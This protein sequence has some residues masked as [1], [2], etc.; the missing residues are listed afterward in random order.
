M[1]LTRTITGQFGMWPWFRPLSREIYFETVVAGGAASVVVA[2]T[3]SLACLYGCAWFLFRIGRRLLG[4]QAAVM[5]VALFLTYNATKFLTAWA[6]GFQDLLAAFL[7]LLAV[8]AW[9][10]G[11][12]G[13]ALVSAALAP[14]AK[15]SGF[16]VYPL[17][18][19]AAYMW[20]GPQAKRDW[21]VRLG[22]TGIVVAS[23]HFLVRWSWQGVGTPPEAVSAERLP[24]VLGQA[25]LGF[26][27]P[28]PPADDAALWLGVGAG[29]ATAALIYVCTSDGKTNH[30]P[31]RATTEGI[32]FVSIA[33]GLAL[34]PV[35]V[36]HLLR[37]TFAHAYQLFPAAPWIALL[38]AGLASALPARVWQT[39]TV[40]LVAW[41]V[42]ALGFRVPDL[43]DPASWSF[44]RWDW[45]EAV[46]F[47]AVSQ[48]L[49]DDIRHELASRPESLI[50]LYEEMP[51][52][53]F[54]QTEDG[55]ATREALQDRTVRAYWASEPPRNVESHRLAILKFDTERFHLERER[56][57]TATAIHRAMNA[58]LAG[59]GR[60]A[61]VFARYDGSPDSARFDRA[62]LL[63]ASALLEDGP[64]AYVQALAVGG[65]ADTTSAT[66]D[67]IAGPLSSIDPNLG[68]ALAEALRHPL[69]AISHAAL[70]DTLLRRGVAARAGMELRI[71]T[72]LDP[73]RLGDRYQLAQ[74]LIGLGGTIEAVAD[75][76][77]LLTEP[78]I[79]VLEG[80]VRAD[81]LR[82]KPASTR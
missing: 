31:P 46:R 64:R 77:Q 17:L 36:G 50:V 3:L 28:R 78:H 71:A 9:L 5:S 16:Y 10:R 56:W 70:A 35:V 59:R 39:A 75:L 21:W 22:V 2:R 37:L 57:S 76:Q 62:Y 27:S 29:V 81:L 15:E 24:I 61:G 47:S 19:L 52:S 58:I 73:S 63:A 6:S 72:T 23:V 41:N 7:V 26:V 45:N 34:T 66:P 33:A 82:L 80:P 38:V 13:L 4:A 43:N 55:P 25:L 30:L 40:L 1:P 20:P 32:R 51:P 79:G 48:R 54:F 49:R 12:R 74:I 60:M 42:W 18:G 69:T 65:L 44:R 11:N 53:T 68:N 8:D 14:F 67:S